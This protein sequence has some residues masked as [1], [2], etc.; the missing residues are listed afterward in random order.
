MAHLFAGPLLPRFL[1]RVALDGAA[2]HPLGAPGLHPRPVFA[3]RPLVWCAGVAMCP[4]GRPVL[5]EP[6]LLWVAHGPRHAAALLDPQV[7]GGQDVA[8]LYAGRLAPVRVLAVVGVG[9]RVAPVG[10]MLEEVLALLLH[11]AVEVC[12]PGVHTVGAVLARPVFL[13]LFPV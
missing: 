12:V 3:V 5:V 11:F 2:P 10:R 6:F 8:P 9:V 13:D 7:A 4:L 1:L